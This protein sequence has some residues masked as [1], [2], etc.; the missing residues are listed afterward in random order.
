MEDFPRSISLTLTNRCNLKCRMCGQW[1]KKGYMH[2]RK[3]YFTDELSFPEWKRLIDECADHAITSV[4]LRGGEVFLLPGIMDFIHY[5]HD[6][7]IFTS[8][9]T[10][11]TM[12]SSFAEDLV[13]AAG[14]VHLSISVDGPEEIHD[15]VRGVQGCFG[16]IKKN[17]ARVLE[18]EKRLQKE[19]SKSITFTI[20][21]Y[22]VNSLGDMPDVARELGFK[23]I[24]IVPYYYFPTHVGLQYE[25]ELQTHFQCPA[26]SWQGFHHEESGVDI[27]VFKTQFRKYLDNLREIYSYPYMP[28][29]VD[30]YVEW[31]SHPLTQVGPTE[32]INVERLIDIQPRGDA[33]FCVDFPDYSMGNVAQSSISEVWNSEKAAAFRAYRKKKPLAVCYR[34]GAKFMG[35]Q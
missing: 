18:I 34:C 31:F 7:G 22:N 21:Q 17:M 2:Q 3:E 12:L 9:D 20:S 35:G 16:K 30:E 15:A 25:E 5:I 26:Y 28:L 27:S 4:L 10:N 23:T 33:N 13:K 14:K 8:I 1:S 19:M 32:C 11:G 6:K 24:T 29:T